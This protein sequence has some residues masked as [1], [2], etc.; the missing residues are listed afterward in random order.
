MFVV[1]LLI[2]FSNG[3]IIKDFYKFLPTLGGAYYIKKVS[4]KELKNKFAKCI[5][6]LITFYVAFF[7]IPLLL[8][9]W[10]EVLRSR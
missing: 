7:S 10:R 8:D 5:F 3:I 6:I 4:N 9:Y 1:S 2:V